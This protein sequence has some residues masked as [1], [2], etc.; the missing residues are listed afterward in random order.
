MRAPHRTEI[1]HRVLKLMVGLTG[2]FLAS[3][4]SLLSGGAILSI[5]Q[6][7]CHGGWARDFFVGSMFAIAAFMAAYNGFSFRE[8][9][10]AKVTALAAIGVAWFPTKCAADSYSMPQAHVAAAA[11]MFAM[12]ATMCHIFYR[13]ARN[14]RTTRANRRAVL[15][16][17]C[18]I[19]ILASMGL[20]IVNHFIGNPIKAVI[21]RLEF[22]CE[23]AALVAFGTAWLAASHVLPWITGPEERWVKLRSPPVQ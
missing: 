11:V 20:V 4:T 15:Y 16:A 17:L 12:L 23:Q 9:L 10:V 18:G 21:P 2:L 19:T 1:D 6:S 14:R 3:T 13:R 22:Y 8:M 7:H 5:S